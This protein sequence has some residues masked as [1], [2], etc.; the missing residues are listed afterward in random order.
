VL[1]WLHSVARENNLH[2]QLAAR[3]PGPVPVAT[4]VRDVRIPGGPAAAVWGLAGEPQPR[5]RLI[6]LPYAH[7]RPGS[8]YNASWL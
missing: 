4:A 3:R 8:P 1:F 6:D 5:R 2:H 7:G